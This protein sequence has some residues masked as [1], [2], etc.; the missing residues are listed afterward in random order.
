MTAN[1]Q[2]VRRI[3]E[4]DV[5]ASKNFKMTQLGLQVLNRNADVEDWSRTMKDLWTV[6]HGNT[7]FQFAVQFAIGDGVNFGESAYGEKYAQALDCSDVDYST[8]VNWAWVSRSVPMEIRHDDLS[9]S[10]H[11]EVALLE[12]NSEKS[13][14]LLKALARDMPSR[15]LHSLIRRDKIVKM[16]EDLPDDERDFWRDFADQLNLP[17]QSRSKKRGFDWWLE[18]SSIEE[19]K[20]ELASRIKLDF[21]DWWSMNKDRLGLVEP[22]SVREVAE[23]IWNAAK[24]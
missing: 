24:Q 7:M 5:L 8:I 12:D 16:T 14:Y 6:W 22:D 19:A 17:W 2:L 23:R 11:R 15:E 10:H 20:M 1:G 3:V 4:C 18:N 9:F 21:I 13:D